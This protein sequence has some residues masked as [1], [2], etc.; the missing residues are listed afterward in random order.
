M[1]SSLVILAETMYFNEKSNID[2]AFMLGF[3]VFLTTN[4]FEITKSYYDNLEEK[5]GYPWF[6]M[7]VLLNLSRVLFNARK[8]ESNTD[9]AAIYVLTIIGCIFACY[10]THKEY[11]D[12]SR[13]F[14]ERNK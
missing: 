13:K 6:F 5:V 2:K 8:T 12:Y 10:F 9:L 14:E 4:A 7:L 11:M 3:T 1:G